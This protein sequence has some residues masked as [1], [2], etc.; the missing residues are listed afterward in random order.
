M[1]LHYKF[2]KGCGVIGD[3]RFEG[4]K[5]SFADYDKRGQEESGTGVNLH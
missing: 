3:L 2:I 1:I 5:R 4:S